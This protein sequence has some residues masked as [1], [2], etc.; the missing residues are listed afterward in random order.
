MIYLCSFV[1]TFLSL[2]FLMI[3]IL[4]IEKPGKDCYLSHLGIVFINENHEIFNTELCSCGLS[5]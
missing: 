5:K 2:V 3:S 1:L 4:G